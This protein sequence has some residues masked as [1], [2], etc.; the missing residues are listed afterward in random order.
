MLQVHERRAAGLS[1]LRLARA[2]L[3]L[4]L[5]TG[6]CSTEGLAFRQDTRLDIVAPADRALVTLPVD[7]RWEVRDQGLTGP[8]AVLVDR[9]PP[10]PGRTLASLVS[11]EP[12]CVPSQG[13]PD[14]AYLAERNIFR[15]TATSFRVERV[16]DDGVEGRRERHEV[17]VVL[18]DA[19]GRRRGESAFSVEFEVKR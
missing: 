3:G 18:L 12:G 4:A 7:V 11:D 15:T 19:E 1:P 13:C 16:R 6:A 8:F 10:A 2:L 17:T 5:I 14:A 9:A